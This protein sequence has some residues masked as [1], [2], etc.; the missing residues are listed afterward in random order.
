MCTRR[1]LAD[2][3]NIQVDK[4]LFSMSLL[5]G[6]GITAVYFVYQVLVAH[7]FA[8]WKTSICDQLTSGLDIE[9]YE[10]A[11]A[12]TIANDCELI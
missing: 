8:E 3:K 7:K 2:Y 4:I 6:V 9:L 1:V 10:Q 12:T 11:T 5:Q